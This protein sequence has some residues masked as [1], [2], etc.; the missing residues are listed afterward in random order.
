MSCR[1]GPSDH[2]VLGPSVL[3][4]KVGDSFACH[5][6]SGAPSFLRATVVKA[7]RGRCSG[8]A[9]PSGEEQEGSPGKPVVVPDMAESC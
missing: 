4:Q 6:G 8:L 7:F 1:A 2:L 5:R 9:R 3:Q